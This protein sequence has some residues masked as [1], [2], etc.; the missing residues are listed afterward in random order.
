ML[1]P[2]ARIAREEARLATVKVKVW[3]EENPGWMLLLG[4]ALG[5]VAGRVLLLF[6]PA[7]DQ[8]LRVAIRRSRDAA[9][10]VKDR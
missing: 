4:L 7:P 5:F 3:A 1:E 9:A 8:R 10:S 2:L 6:A